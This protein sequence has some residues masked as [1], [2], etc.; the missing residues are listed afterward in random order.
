MH[1]TQRSTTQRHG[2]KPFE[3]N[4]YFYGKLLDTFHFELETN[5]NNAKRWMIN[6]TVLGSGVICGLNVQPGP[7]DTTIVVSPGAALDQWGR[8]IIVPMPTDPIPIP[9]DVMQRASQLQQA[10]YKDDRRCVQVMIC[11]HECETD[12]V[13][14]LAG[15]C[16]NAEACAPGIIREQYRIEFTEHCEQ[17]TNDECRFPH[18]VSGGKIDYPALVKWVT[19]ERDCLD[20]PRTPC[21]RL[22]HVFISEGQGHRCDQGNIDIT[23]RPIVYANDLLFDILLGWQSEP[24]GRRGK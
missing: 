14:V 11:Y 23:V 24:Y 13:P 17:P 7:T 4:R 2:L 21:I 9:A 15:D 18:L 8:E 3:R 20:L 10:Q 1:G 5:Y 22:A 19:L 16:S 6:R 12:P